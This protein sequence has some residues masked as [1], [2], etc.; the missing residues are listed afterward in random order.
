[1]RAELIGHFKPCMTEIYLYIDARM[2]Y[3]IHTHPYVYAPAIGAGH[4]VVPSH[5]ASTPR[6]HHAELHRA[7]LPPSQH[8]PQRVRQPPETTRILERSLCTYLTA[9][10]TEAGCVGIRDEPESNDKSDNATDSAA[11]GKEGV[12]CYLDP[13]LWMI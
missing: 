6:Y 13:E 11:L 12:V 10:P 1:M 2:A 3:Y 5:Q 7:P 8:I 9:G 4:L